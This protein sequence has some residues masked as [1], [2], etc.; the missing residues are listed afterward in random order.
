MQGHLRESAVLLVE[1]DPSERERLG[2]LLEQAGLTALLCPGGTEPDYTCVGAREGMCPLVGA[3]DVVVLDMSLDSEAMMMG[4]TAE[5]LLD[6][7]LSSS[8]PVV[9][10][11]RILSTKSRANSL[12]ST[13]MPNATGSWVPLSRCSS[14]GDEG[15][16]HEQNDAGM[17]RARGLT[18]CQPKSS[19]SCCWPPR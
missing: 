11:G 8:R 19:F 1:A 10:L 4:T 3:V 14:A 17:V 18:Q 7:Y 12:G 5:E 6:L 16:P 2:S 13:G 9:V 15:G